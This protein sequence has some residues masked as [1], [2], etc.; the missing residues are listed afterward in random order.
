MTDLWP[1]ELKT[2]EVRPPVLILQEQGTILGKR[3]KNLVLG[4]VRQVPAG[5]EFHFVFMI[6]APPLRYSFNLLEL[7]YG[8]NF[9]PLRVTPAS[10]VRQEAF[11]GSSTPYLT[12]NTEDEFLEMLSKIF[13]ASVTQRLISALIAQMEY[14]TA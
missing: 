1:E 7:K 9:Y 5:P 3:T 11:P 10:E 12:A 2:I 6:D 4:K 8:I 13:R 14:K